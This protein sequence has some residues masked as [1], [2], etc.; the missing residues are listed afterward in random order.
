MIDREG[1]LV[2]IFSIFAVVMLLSLAAWFFI[3]RNTGVESIKV[4]QVA[5]MEINTT[6]N[7]IYTKEKNLS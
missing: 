6:V 1:N 2:K 4:E 7:V 5:Q 3:N